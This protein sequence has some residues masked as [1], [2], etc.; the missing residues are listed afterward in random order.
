M[1]KDDVVFG[2]VAWNDADLGSGGGGSNSFLRLQEGDNTVR[3]LGNPVQAYVHW[4]DLPNGKKQKVNSPI[5][6]P[7]L[8]RRLEEAG[9]PKKATWFLRVLDRSDQTF[10]ILEVGPQIYRGI[11]ALYEN[12]KWG[13]VSKYDITIKKGKKGTNPLYNVSPDPAEPLPS[14]LKAQLAEFTEKVKIENFIK[15]AEPAKVRELLGWSAETTSSSK[16]ASSTSEE[17]DYDFET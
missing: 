14:E 12:K 3:V 11:K 9:F 8:V 16:G 10:K 5:S 4:L 13:P 15:P 17:F 2:E 6:D 1:S 7:E